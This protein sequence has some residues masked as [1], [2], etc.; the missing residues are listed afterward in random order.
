[1]LNSQNLGKHRS[2]PQNAHP[3]L[4]RRI[5]ALSPH[6]GQDLTRGM[7]T[8][9]RSHRASRSGGVCAVWCWYRQIQITAHQQLA[10]LKI[11]ILPLAA[12]W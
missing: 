12:E 2:D 11:A 7:C 9:H 1:V 6:T 4:E 8:A 3:C 10:A 5:E